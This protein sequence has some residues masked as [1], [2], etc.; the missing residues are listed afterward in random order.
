M[1]QEN[2]EQLIEDWGEA[3]SLCLWLDDETI[4]IFTEG[5]EPRRF[6][7]TVLRKDGQP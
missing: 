7:L 4:A 1:G 2:P 6:Y 5:N 3:V